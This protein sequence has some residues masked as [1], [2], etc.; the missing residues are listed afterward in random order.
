MT[1]A[2][3]VINAGFSSIKFA[4]YAGTVTTEA[5]LNRKGTG[6]RTSR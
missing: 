4:A 3:L 2:I 5:D 1:D 6:Q